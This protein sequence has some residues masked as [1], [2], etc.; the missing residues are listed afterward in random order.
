MLFEHSDMVIIAGAS[1]L[2]TNT[3]GPSKVGKLYS[4]LVIILMII[5]YGSP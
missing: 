1:A 5:Q 3:G 2:F 4:L